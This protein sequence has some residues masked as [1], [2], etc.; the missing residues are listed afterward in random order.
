VFSSFR[1]FSEAHEHAIIV[2][3]D[4]LPNSRIQRI[5]VPSITIAPEP[6]TNSF[7]IG[8][9]GRYTLIEMGG[10]SDE[11]M[12]AVL[13]RLDAVGGVLDQIVLTHHH[14]DHIS[15]AKRLHEATGAPVWIHEFDRDELELSAVQTYT[16]GTK[17]PTPVGDLEVLHTPGHAKGHGCFY[18]APEEALFSGDLV[19]GTGYVAILPPEGD[20]RVYLESLRRVRDLPL[21]ALYPGHGPIVTTPYDKI[22]EYIDHRLARERKVV[23]ALETGAEAVGELLEIVYDDV[24]PAL[25]FLAEG[26][27]TAHLQKL[28]EEG[29]C[30]WYVASDGDRRYQPLAAA[31]PEPS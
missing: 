29:E 9:D 18:Y 15:G 25:L 8:D 26:S 13:G 20:M 24:D 27:L 17:I 31:L 16:D 30:R 28:C 23:R 22:D 12:D 10:E 3:V 19:N 6:F 2:L 5:C 4:Q 21:R 14:F 1:A 7:L 11:A